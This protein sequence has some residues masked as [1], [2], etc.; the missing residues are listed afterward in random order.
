MP[1]QDPLFDLFET[2]PE[3]PEPAATPEPEPEHQPEVQ[4]RID[5]LIPCRACPRRTGREWT[6]FSGGLC[7]VCSPVDSDEWMAERRKRRRNGT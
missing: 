7:M 5:A 4:R 3:E 2:D 1:T 6:A